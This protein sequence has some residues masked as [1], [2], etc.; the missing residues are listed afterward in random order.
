MSLYELVKGAGN[1]AHK[2]FMHFRISRHHPT[3]RL[4]S[5]QKDD[6]HELLSMSAVHVMKNCPHKNMN[7]QISVVFLL[8][9]YYFRSTTRSSGGRGNSPESSFFLLS[10]FFLSFPS[11]FVA[12]CH[13]SSLLFCF[14]FVAHLICHHP[15]SDSLSWSTEM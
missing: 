13:N 7:Q 15:K 14:S 10:Y 12:I 9:S 4:M 5:T 11:F 8:F 3:R 1:N 6:K 2:S